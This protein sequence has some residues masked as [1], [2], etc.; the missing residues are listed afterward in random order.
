MYPRFVTSVLVA[1]AILSAPRPLAAQESFLGFDEL[2]IGGAASLNDRPIN[3]YVKFEGLFPL[4]QSEPTYD[5]SPAWLFSPRP[6]VGASISLHGKTNQA[7][8]GLAW[9]LPIYGPFFAEMTFGGLVH[10][11]PLF[12]KSPERPELTT[13]F[14]FR[15]SIAIGYESDTWR[16]VASADHGSNGNL[17][18]HNR[19][20]NH[21]GVMLGRKFGAAAKKASAPS[22]PSISDFSWAGFYA[23][24]S[25][26]V[27]YGKMDW[28]IYEPAAPNESFSGMDY[29]V[30]VGG[31]FG[32]NL[33]IGSFVTGVEA[34]IYAQHLTNSKTRFTPI[35]EEIS[36]LSPWFATARARI[37][38]DVDR[39]FYAQRLLLYATGGAA[40][41]QVNKSYCNPPSHKCYIQATGDVVS[42]GW[43]TEG[44]SKLGW[45]AG[46]GIEIPLAPRASAKFEYLYAQFGGLSFANGPIRNDVNFSEQ[47][48][49]AG[50]SFRFGANGA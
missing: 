15:E 1:L 6:L 3:D 32:Y 4:L 41:A 33:V 7:Y 18:Y 21:F 20:I 38:V 23:G 8:A 35:Q 30:N 2:R 48:L 36:A 11:Q 26:G 43:I 10:D 37:G 24:L 39:V 49:R 17:G 34:D 13:R 50:I 46:G 29:S 44:G 14:L 42:D 16:I 47:S 12:Q 40:F 28:V 25:G 5:S 19:S 31:Y 22:A 45:T 27:A 9:D